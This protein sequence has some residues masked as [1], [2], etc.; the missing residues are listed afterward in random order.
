MIMTEMK[1]S[2]QEMRFSER[3]MY[4]TYL[5]RNSKYSHSM[6]SLIDLGNDDGS[7]GI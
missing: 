5:N 1:F 7:G 2:E 4:C 3:G 6:M